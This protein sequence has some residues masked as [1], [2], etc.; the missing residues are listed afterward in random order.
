MVWANEFIQMTSSECNYLFFIDLLVKERVSEN[1]SFEKLFFS[2]SL[3]IE[4]I[5]ADKIK[6]HNLL[7]TVYSALQL[8]TYKM[9]TPQQMYTC[10]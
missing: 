2:L 8:D 1:Q 7:F 9:Y 4:N 6:K 10:A 5:S 3:S